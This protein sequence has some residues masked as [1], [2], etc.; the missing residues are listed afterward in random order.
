MID[1]KVSL[2][3]EAICGLIFA[4]AI[5][6]IPA[7]LTSN[8][9]DSSPLPSASLV[10]NFITLLAGLG[11]AVLGSLVTGRVWEAQARSAKKEKQKVIYSLYLSYK[12]AAEI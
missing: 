1:R 8:S 9:G 3:L 4:A 12:C 6:L 7:V 11:G 5:V 2:F 10:A